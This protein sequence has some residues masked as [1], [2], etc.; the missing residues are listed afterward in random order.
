[1]RA[2]LADGSIAIVIG[3]AA[4]AGKGVDY[5]DLALVVIDEEQRFGTAAKAKLRGMGAGHVL[6]LSATPI[7]RTLQSALVGLQ[8]I[9]VIATPPARRQPI[10]TVVA[11]FDGEALARALRRERARGGQSFVVVP[12]IEDIAPLEASLGRLVP[13]LGV[14]VA[15]GRMDATALDEAMTGFAAGDGD[16]LLATNI[17]EAGLD[18]PRANTMVVHHADRFGLSQLHQSRGRVGRGGRRGQIHLL[19]DGEATIAEATLK[20]LRTLQAFDQLGAGFAISARDLDMR[21]AGDLV[22]EEQA[23]HM[24]MIGTDLYQN[25]LGHA[26]RVARGEGGSVWHPVLNLGVA[27]RLPEE[28]IPEVDVRLSLYGHLAHIDRAGALDA[29]EAELED[30]FGPLPDP[31]AR[32][33]ATARIGMLARAAGIRQVDT[34]PGAIAVTPVDPKARPTPPFLAAKGRWLARERIEDADERLARVAELLDAQV[35]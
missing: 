16:I 13:E 33:I 32:L 19:T 25:L 24:K 14:V 20:R 15:H 5:A 30:R 18:V 21:G 6:T 7:P 28:W 3:T 1:M 12:R 27:G 11:P 10:R 34:G 29:F 35:D 26:L 4:V 17:I 8:A 9:S 2:G 22:G 31:A 23:G